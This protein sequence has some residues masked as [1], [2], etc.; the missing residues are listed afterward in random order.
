MLS[1]NYNIDAFLL[2][3]DA[4]YRGNNKQ[5]KDLLSIV[6]GIETLV[7]QFVERSTPI[8]PFVNQNIDAL[9]SIR[10]KSLN[11]LI[12]NDNTMGNFD[13][14]AE[15]ALVNFKYDPNFSLLYENV[16]FA[17][18]TNIRSINYLL[19]PSK[20]PHSSSALDFSRI[21]AIPELSLTQ[22]LNVFTMSAPDTI[23]IPYTDW[24]MSSLYMEFGILA[25]FVI[26][27]EKWSIDTAK[28]NEL[29]FFIADAAQTFGAVTKEL[30]PKPSKV[31]EDSAPSFSNSF[32]MEQTFL[33]EQDIENF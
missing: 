5:D 18:R 8:E 33:A 31:Y 17:I 7:K 19:N 6:G 10:I 9:F 27:R 25:A 15:N 14:F 13:A 29:A 26:H 3:L 16:F 24:L 23:A 30:K 32:L 20:Q 11:W 4:F 12:K 21:D 28:I 22:Y 2:P 1:F